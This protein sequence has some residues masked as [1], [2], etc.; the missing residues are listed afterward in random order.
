MRRILYFTYAVIAYL[1]F[2]AGV[3]PYAVGFLGNFGV[4]TTLDGEPI[5]PTAVAIAINL[6]LLSVFAV[7]H[8]V[9]ARPWFKRWWTKF[10][11]QPIERS[12]YVLAS[13]LAMVLIFAFWEPIGGV[14]WQVPGTGRLVLY[15]LYGLGWM[16]VL[17]ATFLISHSDL[18]GLRQ[19]WFELNGKPYVQLPFREPTLYKHVRHPLY[20]GWIMVFWFTPTMTASHL[21]F[22]VVTT[23]YILI[24][25]Q[26]EERDLANSLPGYAEYRKRVPM[27]VPRAS[28]SKKTESVTADVA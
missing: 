22:A 9:M 7:Q 28:S 14:I 3:F 20:V 2:L 24:A 15:T 8:S 12:T 11:P 13:N 27:L 18:F 16:T 19:V 4:P 21:F 6:A 23:A 25:I 1:I 10:V 5:R 17:Y 26:F